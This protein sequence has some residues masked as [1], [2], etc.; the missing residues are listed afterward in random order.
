MRRDSAPSRKNRRFRGVPGP[1]NAR[2]TGPEGTNS[3]SRATRR[4]G[5]C[6]GSAIGRAILP[7]P[8]DRR[9]LPRGGRE[10]RRNGRAAR[11]VARR[12]IRRRGR[13]GRGGRVAPPHAAANPLVTR[14]RATPCD[15][16]PRSI[17]AVLARLSRCVA[18][19]SWKHRSDRWAY[20]WSKSSPGLCH[21]TVVVS[22]PGC[23]TARRSER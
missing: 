23:E 20:P 12:L 16:V 6:C 13:S 19:C 15:W 14:S 4:F 2:T 10:P 1:R 22:A 9:A 18:M 8:R 21:D 7:R 11:G 3:N 5:N 17:C